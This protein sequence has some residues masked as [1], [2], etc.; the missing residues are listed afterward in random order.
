MREASRDPGS[1]TQRGETP[2]VPVLYILGSGH[3]G[4]TL[5]DLLL[6]S[7]P[8]ITGLGEC[9]K[10]GRKETCGC[11]KPFPACR[12]WGGLFRETADGKETMPDT[13]QVY[14]GAGDFLR[15]NGNYRLE[16]AP[17]D[18]RATSEYAAAAAALYGYARRRSNAAA[19]V[20]SSKNV[21]R[22]AF[23]EAKGIVRPV[24]V[25]I[26]RDGRGVM[27]SYMKKGR[28]SLQYLYWWLVSNLKIEL[29]VRRR[30]L[31]RVFLTYEALAGNPAR[32]LARILRAVNLDYRE[33][34][35]HFRKHPHHLVAGN[36][37]RKQGPEEI[38]E[39][40]AWKRA[41]S[42]FHQLAYFVLAGWMHVYYYG[43]NRR[44]PDSDPPYRSG[45]RG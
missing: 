19:L 37:I 10:A 45:A 33:D 11:G 42:P 7:H 14:R 6:D 43:L 25:H 23:L 8:E 1:T 36:Q 5:L 17:G 2:P 13:G 22:V 44:G 26:V 20:D 31:P 18:S 9:E 16:N 15:D 29:L 38:V 34:M 4:S 3:C 32:E 40:R 12:F 28:K 30:R 21:D 41:L 35:L 39:D 24:V 27:W